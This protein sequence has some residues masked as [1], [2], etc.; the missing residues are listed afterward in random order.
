[1]NRGS[2][3]YA[4]GFAFV[5]RRTAGLIRLYATAPAGSA[6]ARVTVT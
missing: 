5:I 4:F 1:M 3:V 2:T 6:P